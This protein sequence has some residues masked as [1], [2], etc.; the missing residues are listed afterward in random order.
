MSRIERDDEQQCNDNLTPASI[1]FT[2]KFG[3]W[4]LTKKNKQNPYQIAAQYFARNRATS[5]HMQQFSQETR[6]CA[7]K[8]IWSNGVGRL[9]RNRASSKVRFPFQEN[10]DLSLVGGSGFPRCGQEK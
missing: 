1:G 3:A 7:A 6:N 10:Y 5:G 2:Q 4:V 9:E 8:L